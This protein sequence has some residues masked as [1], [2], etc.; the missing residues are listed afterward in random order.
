[1]R[2]KFT[3]AVEVELDR[4][5]KTAWGRVQRR[6]TRVMPT[7]ADGFTI[8][9]NGPLKTYFPAGAI[10]ELPS[11]MCAAYIESKCADVYF[12]VNGERVADDSAEVLE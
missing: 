11:E 1:M 8:P 10:V 12:G 4:I 3:K 5:P 9:R 2:I 7:A 6:S